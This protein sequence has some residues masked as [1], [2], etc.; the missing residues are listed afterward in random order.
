MHNLV[1]SY[2]LTVKSYEYV[3]CYV[4]SVSAISNQKPPPPSPEDPT[5]SWPN[6]LLLPSPGTSGAPQLSWGLFVFRADG[7]GC[8][9]YWIFP[10]FLGSTLGL[11]LCKIPFTLF[12]AVVLASQVKPVPGILVTRRSMGSGGDAC[13]IIV[14]NG[15]TFRSS[16]VGVGVAVAAAVRI[17]VV[18]VAVVVVS[19]FRS[20]VSCACLRLSLFIEASYPDCPSELRKLTFSHVLSRSCWG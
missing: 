14:I 16:T 18:E 15:M 12:L 1:N 2:V 19:R 20:I 5:T 11:Q 7:Q 10:G 4:R 6:P 17:A 3:R 9:A 13:F 8:L